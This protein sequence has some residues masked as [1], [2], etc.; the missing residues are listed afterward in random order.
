MPENRIIYINQA[1]VTVRNNKKM[2]YCDYQIIGQVIEAVNPPDTIETYVFKDREVKMC[3]PC[4]N[5]TSGEFLGL[6]EAVVF[7]IC[8]GDEEE[9]FLSY[10]YDENKSKLL[11]LFTNV[12]YQIVLEA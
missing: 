6:Y 3:R 7:I 10:D 9:L 4:Y 1:Y 8:R 2:F 12:G 11:Y 5:P